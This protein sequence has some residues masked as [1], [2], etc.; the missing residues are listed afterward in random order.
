MSADNQQPGGIR[1]KRI[2]ADNIVSGIQI[3]GGDAQSASSLVQLAQAI[4]RGEITADDITTRNLVSG[5]QY[6]ADPAHATTE[7]VRCELASLRQQVETA[8]AA[9]E[10]PD[11]DEAKAATEDLTV[12]E[13]ELGKSQPNGEKVLKRL[14]NVNEILTQSAQAAEQAGKIGALVIKLAP[15]AATVWQVT[16]GLLGI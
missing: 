3:Q 1:A 6:I 10:I 11:E 16:R 2:Q 8:I 12:A 5:L 4:Q 15:I 13:K 14:K 7:D 9:Q